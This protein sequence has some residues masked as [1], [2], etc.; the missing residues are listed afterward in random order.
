MPDEIAFGHYLG[1]SRYNHFLTPYFSLFPRDNIH[2]GFFDEIVRDLAAFLARSRPEPL[3]RDM[4]ASLLLQRFATVAGL[5]TVERILSAAVIIVLARLLG[6]EGYGHY[7][8][9]MSAMMLIALPVFNGVPRVAIRQ[10]SVY[11]AREDSA[12]LR[13]VIRWSV[14]ALAALAAAGASLLLLASA[15]GDAL[16]GNIDATAIAATAALLPVMAAMHYAAALLVGMGY[17]VHA[18]APVS[19]V[20]P[21]FFL[22][23]IAAF[24]VT[25]RDLSATSAILLNVAA[26]ALAFAL[27][28]SIVRHHWPLR[29]FAGHAKSHVREWTAS[30]LPFIALSGVGAI[31]RQTDIV[32]LGAIKTTE[33]S[34]IYQVASLTA[35]LTFLGVEVTGKIASQNM[36]ALHAREQRDELQTLITRTAALS[37]VIAIAALIVFAIG[38]REILGLLFGA[39]FSAGHFALIG[40]CIGLTLSAIVGPAGPLMAMAGHEMSILKTAAVAA[41][42]NLV[43]NAL[44]IPHWG[45]TGAAL[46]TG[47]SLA[48]MGILKARRVQLALGIDCGAWRI[49]RPSDGFIRR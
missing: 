44:L 9:A 28:A 18:A 11:I 4:N 16:G 38:G 30:V 31:T 20:R 40:L 25:A 49:F 17:P 39:E 42:C 19:I 3:A 48:L 33:L 41:L 7:A 34:G 15:A 29:D 14:I 23:L 6:V 10:V 37:T 26:A 35:G 12:S 36:A 22:A 5:L 27:L 8:F 21:I 13:G 47:V 45:M 2:V 46:A 32:M 24:V 43:L 1:C